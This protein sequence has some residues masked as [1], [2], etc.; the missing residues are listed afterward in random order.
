MSRTCL[1]PTPAI[2]DLAE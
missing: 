2:K 1:I